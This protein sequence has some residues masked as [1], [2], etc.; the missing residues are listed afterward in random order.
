MIGRPKV[1]EMT[2]AEHHPLIFTFGVLGNIISILMFLSPMFTFIRVY[3]KKSTEGFQSIPYVVALFS[4]MLWIYYA[5]LK[6]GDYLLLS[7]NSF[8]CLV[9]TIYIV[10][11]IFYAEKKAKLLFLMNFAGFLAIV[12]LTR[13]FAKGSSRLHI[14]GWFCVAVSAV[15]FAAPLSVIRLVVRTKS[16]EFMPFTL[17][18]FLTLSAI[19]W[20]LY[21]VLLKDLYIALPNIFGLVFGAIQM[22][23]YVIY[24][25]G[26]KVIELPEKIDMD[27]PIKTFEVHAAVVSLPIPD[28]NYQVNK[29]DNP[30]EQ[31]KPNADSTESLNQEQF[32]VDEVTA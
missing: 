28:D 7:I 19:M 11:F 9:Q 18:L 8:G 10:L 14:V 5:M 17:S 13:F 16:V 20:L 23:L 30:N 21:G 27:S 24:R 12:A 2:M 22:V 25:D 1:E 32:T 26:K 3:K 31:R 29:E 4:C 15:L 6:S